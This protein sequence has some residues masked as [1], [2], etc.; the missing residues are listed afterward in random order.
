MFELPAWL[1]WAAAKNVLG[2]VWNFCTKPPGIYLVLIGGVAL[3]IWWSGQRGYD[4]GHADCEDAHKA[5]SQ[6]EHARQVTVGKGVRADSDKRTAPHKAENK[7]N[8]TIVRT[9]YVHDQALPDAS[10]VC[11]N[12]DDADRLR[13]LK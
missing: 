9:I 2:G 11:V 8:K 1:T 5:A 10:Y 4:R 6:T 7:A 13:D 12:P 3:A